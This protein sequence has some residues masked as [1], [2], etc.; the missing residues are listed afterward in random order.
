MMTRPVPHARAQNLTA[1]SWH[2]RLAYVRR[3]ELISLFDSKGF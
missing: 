2:G 1:T 3:D